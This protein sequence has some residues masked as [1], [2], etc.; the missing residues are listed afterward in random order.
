ME[1]T[2]GVGRERE[3]EEEEEGGREKKNVVAENVVS[4]KKK[5]MRLS[6]IDARDAFQR[7]LALCFFLAFCSFYA[8]SRGEKRC[9]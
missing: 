5:K 7:A 9:S 3:E 1:R 2:E 8:G 4:Q 6:T